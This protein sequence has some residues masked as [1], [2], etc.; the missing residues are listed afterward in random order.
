MSAGIG[1]PAFC[2]SIAFGIFN[3]CSKVFFGKVFAPSGLPR[4]ADLLVRRFFLSSG[5]SFLIALLV[6]LTILALSRERRKRHPA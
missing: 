3:A 1:F 6:C 5:S 2:C 4:A